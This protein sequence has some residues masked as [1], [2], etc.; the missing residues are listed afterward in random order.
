MGNNKN[1]G[2]FYNKKDTSKETVEV[3]YDNKTEE[4]VTKEEVSKAPVEE[5][6]AKEP[7][8]EKQITLKVVNTKRVNFRKI[9]NKDG[10]VLSIL[11]EGTE[12]KKISRPLPEWY[13]VEING[14]VGFI[15]ARY[16]K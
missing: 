6:K 13:E 5:E 11:S 16:L 1:Y 7:E 15:M 2:S 10:K 8:V 9:P 12:V 3:S 14:Q 4:I